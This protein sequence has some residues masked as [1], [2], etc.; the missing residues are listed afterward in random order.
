MLSGGIAVVVVVGL[1]PSANIKRV[2]LGKYRRIVFF[3]VCFLIMT[4]VT[5]IFAAFTT[6]EKSMILMAIGATLFTISDAILSNTYFGRGFD[7][8]IWLFLNHFTYY[9][10]QYLIASSVCFFGK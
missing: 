6:G 8:S 7:G 1:S 5:A 2:E 4:N 10:G 9:A 3:Y